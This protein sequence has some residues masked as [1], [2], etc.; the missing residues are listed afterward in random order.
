MCYDSEWE[1]HPRDATPNMLARASFQADVST[2]STAY[3]VVQH[4]CEDD[5]GDQEVT[6]IVYGTNQVYW[7]RVD[8]SDFESL[9]SMQ[10]A[11]DSGDCDNP[12][13]WQE[14][15]VV[16]CTKKADD[17]LHWSARGLEGVV[18][19]VRDAALEFATEIA[20]SSYRVF[21]RAERRN[22]RSS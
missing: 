17:G 19:S 10:A 9:E 15:Y 2:E 20:D 4:S 3:V 6:V 8:F 18:D 12:G 22:R 16:S 7:D 5:N 13:D 21:R 14:S 11:V 1:V